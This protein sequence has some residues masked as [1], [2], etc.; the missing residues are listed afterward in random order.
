MPAI[1]IRCE[2]HIQC[3]FA[4]FKQKAF[5]NKEICRCNSEIHKMGPGEHNANE[6]V[7]VE[8][9]ESEEQSE[10]LYD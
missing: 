6:K 2:N 7:E 9:W 1:S 3:I 4:F 5:N 8:I 10:R